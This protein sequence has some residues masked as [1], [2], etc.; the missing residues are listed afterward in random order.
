MSYTIKK[1]LCLIIYLTQDLRSTKAALTGGKT[2]LSKSPKHKQTFNLWSFVL[3]VFNSSVK[4]FAQLKKNSIAT[5]ALVS[6]LPQGCYLENIQHLPQREASQLHGLCLVES[7]KGKS[8]NARLTGQSHL[9]FWSTTVPFYFK[10]HTKGN[11]GT[12]LSTRQ[13][14][15]TV[16][17]EYL[18]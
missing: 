15:W 2:R 1:K 10:T 12:W 13:A 5:F 9:L 16:G 8:S 4:H 6:T 18:Q 17:S 11:G 7:S 14:V 3:H